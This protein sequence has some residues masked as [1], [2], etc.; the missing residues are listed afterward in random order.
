VRQVVGCESNTRALSGAACGP[1][2]PSLRVPVRRCK[3]ASSVVL[4]LVPSACSPVACANSAA[5][6]CLL[7]SS[8][9]LVV[10]SQSKQ[11]ISE[12]VVIFTQPKSRHEFACYKNIISA[13]PVFL[14]VCACYESH[15]QYY[16]TYN[17]VLLGRFFDGRGHKIG[18][19]CLVGLSPPPNAGENECLHRTGLCVTRG[20]PADLVRRVRP[21]FGG[22]GACG[23]TVRRL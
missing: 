19:R 8:A 10:V 11:V 14:Q 18:R 22:S 6:A 5:S 3:T 9:R 7:S 16:R 13:S 4:Q 12:V 15:I 17:T 23:F 1:L 21:S 20:V 2:S